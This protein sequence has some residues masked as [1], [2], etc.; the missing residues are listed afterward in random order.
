M[1]AEAWQDILRSRYRLGGRTA[2]VELDCLGTVLEG[3]RRLGLCL[4]DPWADIRRQ[5]IAGHVEAACG[6]PPCWVRRAEP[7]DLREGDVLLFYGSHPWV[8]IVAHAHVWSADIE[9]GSAYARPLFRW[10]KRPA[11][12]WA[13]DPTACSPRPA[14]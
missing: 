8:A 10:Q 2:G 4:P 14:R 3:C 9:L 5:W 7:F 11:E 1:T 12:V 13:H 6:F